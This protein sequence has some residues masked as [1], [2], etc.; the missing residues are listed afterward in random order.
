M[1]DNVFGGREGVRVMPEVPLSNSQ[2]QLSP[3]FDSRIINVNDLYVTLNNTNEKVLAIITA[4][5][6]QMNAWESY[7]SS[8]LANGSINHIR[9]YA[10][11]Q[12]ITSVINDNGKCMRLLNDWY[13]DIG[14]Q[15]N[16]CFEY[17]L[18]YA[19]LLNNLRNLCRNEI[20][21]FNLVMD[22]F[23]MAKS[24]ISKAKSIQSYRTRLYKLDNKINSIIASM[25][26]QL[27]MF[28]R[29]FISL[30]GKT[31]N[32]NTFIDNMNDLSGSG[33]SSLQALRALIAS[34]VNL[35][36]V[37]VINYQI[38]NNIRAVL[39]SLTNSLNGNIPTRAVPNY[40]PPRPPTTSQNV[41][42]PQNVTPM[43]QN[44]IPQNMQTPQNV[45]PMPQNL[46][47]QNT[48]I[49]QNSAPISQNFI[50]QTATPTGFTEQGAV[51][52]SEM[53]SNPEFLR[54]RSEALLSN[55]DVNVTPLPL[56]RPYDIDV[57]MGELHLNF[58]S[59]QHNVKRLKKWYADVVGTV[60]DNAMLE[61][62]VNF[63]YDQI[64]NKT[65]TPVMGELRSMNA[66]SSDK[67]EYVAR[68]RG[69]MTF[70][71]E[72]TDSTIYQDLERM[73]NDAFNAS[74]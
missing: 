61:T 74:L 15:I 73:L 10:L 21:D 11:M 44:L 43:P 52:Q 19:D 49:P 55:V 39:Q 2:F 30:D 38:D 26:L 46:I 34:S 7:L 60:T 17:G 69:Y 35:Q 29:G 25:K 1:N 48:Q 13:M 37:P 68:L 22:E 54:S 65:I 56:A 51:V 67:S 47:P 23:S 9:D 57:S 8:V 3:D 53:P 33:T 63:V 4:F 12:K 64:N 70:V 31:T 59:T 27:D 5:K 42:M 50:P 20:N 6:T 58:I 66:Q 62:L 41:Q 72:A 45:T 24:K 71:D 32:L 40:M 36:N 18:K 14:E 16:S 28:Q